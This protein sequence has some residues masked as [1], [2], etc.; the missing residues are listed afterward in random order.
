LWSAGGAGALLSNGIK[1]VPKLLAIDD[2]R[3]VLNLITQAFVK[4]PIAVQTAISAREG[5]E[6]IGENPDVVLLDIMLPESSGLEVAQEIRELNPKL[7]VIF[8][9]ACENSQTAIEAM[10]LGAYDYLI[11]PLDLPKL[12]EQVDRA[13]E[14][15]RLMQTS[16]DLPASTADDGQAALE[17][18]SDQIVG[19]SPPMQ[20]VFKAIGRVATQTTTVLVLGESG[21]GKE[22]VARAIY[23]H[24][25][26]NEKPFLAV[27]CAA[28]PENLLESELFGHEKGA[29]TSAHQR[30]IGKFEQCSGGTIFLDEVGDMSPLVQSKVLRLLQEQEFER[31]G[32]AETIR[33]DVR[34]IA[35]TNHDLQQRVAE[36][37]FREDLYYRLNG[38]TIK[39]PP[40]RDRNGDLQ[41]L[42]NYF[43]R[44]FN[45]ELNK[46]VRGFAPDALE[47]LVKY[48]WPG[49]VRELEAAVRQ[50]LLQSTGPFVLVEFLPEALRSQALVD[51]HAVAA[52]SDLKPL[53]DQCLRESSKELYSK[54]V[55]A[56]E[57]YVLA[58]VLRHTNGN[59]SRAALMLGI[60]RASLR[61][62]LHALHISVESAIS[63]KNDSD[64]PA[65]SEASPV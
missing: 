37:T 10:K 56:M 34:V 1:I 21:T 58:R 49:N 54:A 32:G 30:R 51:R 17:T 11:K 38:F 57:R 48:A 52:T 31:V 44:R 41:L 16:V 64:L 2:D 61:R 23:H 6:K 18:K 19:H 13:L 62:K 14:I 5:L 29:F 60:T 63:L 15:R 47:V 42:L 40:L 25:S 12:R 7:P 3:V 65:E 33:T 8:I 27:N 46:D 4:T 59:Q 43:L 50:C 9:T 28:I 39:V 45:A 20:E 53:V 35:A 24:G 26:R 22:L 55:E 36:G